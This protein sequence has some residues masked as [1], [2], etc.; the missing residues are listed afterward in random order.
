MFADENSRVRRGQG[1]FLSI[2]LDNQVTKIREGK[3][4]PK[5]L[6]KQQSGGST[7]GKRRGIGG[8]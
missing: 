6:K 5:T 8:C 3:T 2:Y 7:K 4:K 1:Y